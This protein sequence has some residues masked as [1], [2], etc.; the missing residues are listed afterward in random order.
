MTTKA[1]SSK[2]KERK[3]VTNSEK[4]WLLAKQ[5]FSPANMK[6]KSEI[7][8]AQ[9]AL[10]YPII[11]AAVLAIAAI[12]VLFLTL[13]VTECKE[14]IKPSDLSLIKYPSEDY[15]SNRSCTWSFKNQSCHCVISD[16]AKNELGETY[17]YQYVIVQSYPNHNYR[18][19]AEFNWCST[20]DGFWDKDGNYGCAP[21]FEVKC[22]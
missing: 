13:E 10:E 11:I 16:H 5:P 3:G 2:R 17:L 19:G 14:R 7:K 9:G 12:V 18:P 22:E 4:N 8:K 6:A 1:K 21:T 15:F 20:E